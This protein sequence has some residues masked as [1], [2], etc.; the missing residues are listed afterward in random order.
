[1]KTNKTDE[2]IVKATHKNKKNKNVIADNKLTQ[3][4]KKKNYKKYLCGGPNEKGT[5]WPAEQYTGYKYERI[6]L[7]G[8]ERSWKSHGKVLEF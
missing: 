2:N 1:V 5:S 3:G 7:S 4:I 8:F 6:A